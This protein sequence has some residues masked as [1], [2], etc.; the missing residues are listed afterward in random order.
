[1]YMSVKQSKVVAS[2]SCR[3]CIP[4]D[5]RVVDC[6]DHFTYYLGPSLNTA[7][8]STQESGNMLCGQIECVEVEHSIWNTIPW[9]ASTGVVTSLGCSRDRSER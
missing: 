3:P 4:N 5:Y 1:M 7:G 2:Y 9:S 8:S 6:G